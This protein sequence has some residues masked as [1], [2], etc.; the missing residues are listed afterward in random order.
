M[1]NRSVIVSAFLAGWILAPVACVPSD[2]CGSNL[3]YRDRVC[4]TPLPPDAAPTNPEPPV[5]TNDDAEGGTATPT[6][7][8]EA[9][10]TAAFGTA[11]TAATAPTT[12]TG[13][14][15][16]CTASPYAPNGYCTAQ[17]CD[18]TPSVCPTG[19]TCKQMFTSPFFCMKP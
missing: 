4:Q 18:Q 5:S 15:S 8:A 3:E 9:A 17:G 10:P 14:T 13:V 16:F 7:D 11:C 19:W 12:C 6:P 2:K 1:L